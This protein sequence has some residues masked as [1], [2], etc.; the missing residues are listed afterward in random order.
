MPN[1]ITR[2]TVDS[3]VIDRF[4]NA[5]TLFERA[6]RHSPD[7]VIVSPADRG[8]LAKAFA[9]VVN[10]GDL[11][12]RTKIRYDDAQPQGKFR[13]ELIERSENPGIGDFNATVEA[14]LP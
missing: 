12:W 7:V 6:S 10:D 14:E 13:L 5:F 9:C 1:I 8:R 2:T 3:V 4:A 11:L